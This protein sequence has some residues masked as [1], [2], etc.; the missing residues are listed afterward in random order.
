MNLIRKITN[1][2]TAK[3]EEFVMA[4]KKILGYRPRKIKFYKEA[5][6]HSSLKKMSDTGNPMNYERLEFLGDAIL[7]AVI[8]N[9]LFKKIPSGDEG[10]LTQMRSK[11]VSREHLNE[12]GK[13]LDL[14]QFV[15]SSVPNSNFGDNIHGNLFEALIGAIHSDRGYSFTEKFI[16][17]FVIEPYVDIERLEGKITS[18]KSVLIEWSQKNKKKIK[19]NVYEDTGN[20]TLK[21]F[22]VKLL[23]D[24]ELISKGRAT[25]KKKAEEIASKRAYYKLKP[26]IEQ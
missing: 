7:G 8:A 25:S 11:I 17:R 1:S 4:I 15:K 16:Y 3:D 19:Y 5:F 2:H 14:I 6:T 21:H 18:Y 26:Q 20:D 9:Y 22:S 13:D 12:L 10:Y 24:L 23:V